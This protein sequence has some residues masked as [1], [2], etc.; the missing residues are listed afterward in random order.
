MDWLETMK[1]TGNEAITQEVAGQAHIE[2]RSLGVF[3]GADRIDREQTYG[4]NLVKVSKHF[5]LMEKSFDASH[6]T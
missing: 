1:K 2:Q 4:K 3:A 6:V 5:I